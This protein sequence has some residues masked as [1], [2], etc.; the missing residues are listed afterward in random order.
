MSSKFIIQLRK[1]GVITV[2]WIGMGIFL[3]YYDYLALNSEFVVILADHYSF[4]Q[5]LSL[6]ILACLMGSLIL[7]SF[8]VFYINEKFR[9]KSY[10]YTMAAVIISFVVTSGILTYVVSMSVAIL[11]TGKGWFDFEAV[12]RGM[13]LMLAPF[14]TKDILIWAII[15][16]ITQLLL[17]MNDK[18]GQGLLWDFIR[19]KYRS[20]QQETRIF[21]FVDLKSSTT[22]AEKLGNEKYYRLIRDYFADITDPIINNKGQIYQY[23]GDEVIISWKMETGIENS[24]C[25]KCYFD[26]VAKIESL[27]E[28]YMD[29]YGLIPEFKAG[30]HFGQVTA[31]EIGI[32]KRDI[33]FSGDVLNTTARIQTQ[34][35]EHKV[36]ILSSN[37]LLN[38]MEL[39]SYKQIKI[40]S[41]S[42]KGKE[43]A[44]ELSTVEVV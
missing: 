40:G 34:C 13:K 39:N 27:G 36:P 38:E 37:E 1:L 21:M 3:T 24:H 14:N 44:V 12:D 20:P 43:Q 8:L 23:A 11:E 17:S 28:K 26:M 32:I 25:L 19:G 18:F 29:R 5:N 31:G 15:V 16:S 9:D 6:M 35:N 41:I 30:L 4:G 10:G 33:T 7:G 42:L 22:I 2:A